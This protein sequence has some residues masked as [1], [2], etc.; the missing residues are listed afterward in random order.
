MKPLLCCGALGVEESEELVVEGVAREG[1]EGGMNEVEGVRRDTVKVEGMRKDAEDE[2]FVRRE[3]EEVEGLRREV[4]AGRATV[5][6][7]EERRREEVEDL[8]ERRRR[9][10]VKS[11]EQI[12]ELKKRL[13][14]VQHAKVI[15]VGRCDHG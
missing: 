11:E 10:C 3:S 14:V 15:E 9:E 7:V 6:A 13:E 1:V 8:K 12:F 2:G 5:S 4:E